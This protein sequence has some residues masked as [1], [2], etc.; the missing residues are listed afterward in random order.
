MSDNKPDAPVVNINGHGKPNIVVCDLDGTLCN[1]AHREH[2]AR[3]GEWAQF[4]MLL[5]ADQPHEDVRAVVNTLQ[6]AGN[7]IVGLTGR[8]ERWRP[9][10]LDW[11]RN[12]NVALD[13][14]LMRPDDDF[15]PDVKLK[16]RLVLGMFGSPD[17]A[18][19]EV[20]LI[21][22]DRDRMVE[23]WR[24]LGFRCWQTQPGGY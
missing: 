24:N 14:L 20:L 2:L 15:T 18:R 22:E 17:V 19:Q 9:A 1:S 11:L 16:P 7:Y 8:I 21:L 23:E 5:T 12:H 13:D 10:T 4:H 3:H 6:R